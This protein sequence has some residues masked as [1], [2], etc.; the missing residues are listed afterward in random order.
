MSIVIS[1]LTPS[2]LDAVDELM[3]RNSRTLGFLPKQA[4]RDYL[5]KA[6][7]FGART[8]DGE[9]IGYLLYGDYPDYYRIAQLCVSEESRKKGIAKRLVD[10]LKET[11]TSQKFI[12][13]N[14]RRDFAAHEVWPQLGFVPLHEKPGRSAAG[15]L[16]TRWHLS[17]SADDQ[18]GLFRA[19]TS[20]ESL[21][22]VIDAQIFFD[23][24]EADNDKTAPSKALFNDF[25]T[26]ALSLWITD[27]LFVE[28]DRAQNP[29]QRKKSREK[30]HTSS[31]ISKIEHDPRAADHWEKILSTILPADS[32]S[33][34]SDIRHLAKTAA[35]DVDIF[36]TRDQ[37]LLHKSEKIAALTQMKISSPVELILK[38][39]HLSGEES[40]TSKRIS[41]GNL[42]WKRI[43]SDDLA[44]LSLD[45]F[46]NHQETK[47]KFREKLESILARPNRNECELLKVSEDVLAVRALT[48][49]S[50][51]R[52]PVP[53][54]RL[55]RQ[56]DRFLFGRFLIADMIYKALEKNLNM[57][58]CDASSLTSS[59]VPHLLDVG[60]TKSHGSFV[61][62]CFPYHLTREEVL[63][64]ITE[65]CPESIDDYRTMSD[66]D[67]ERHCSPLSLAVDQNCF[68][69][70][71]KP[72][73]ALSLIDSS[74]SAEDLFGG[75]T[76]VL[77]RWDNVYYRRK[78]HHHILNLP[79]RVLWYESSP[80][81]RIVALSH[82][83]AVEIDVPKVLFKRFKKFGILEWK[84]VFQLCQGDHSR[85]IMALK[86]SHTFPFRQPISLDTVRDVYENEGSNL[87]L[88][89]PSR[90]P[91]EVF[92]KL[93]LL[94]YPEQV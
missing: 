66:R 71:I 43:A 27:E 20:A 34:K 13:L 14:C 56:A 16:L 91:M 88:Q 8:S 75:K 28:I 47:G 26:D 9:L 54:A 22:V 89:S 49:G 69:V 38:L 55:A 79:A 86:F 94:G 53:L 72:G 85:Q 45:S 42:K 12:R 60:F 51:K 21:D 33:R 2:D 59:L 52:L 31:T 17:L 29:N 39:H 74:Q 24:Y 46:L 67:L 80:K 78:T 58:K 7:V 77:L 1:K 15:H 48:H 18:L 35:S 50:D 32:R 41:G 30:A 84:D 64:R 4:L 65:L 76:S 40:Y 11:V 37:A 3:R 36:V 44:S 5:E 61:R 6:G 10:A 63:S 82:L 93:L 62:F 23:F 81:K 90:V 92:R 73:Y 70:P 25:S 19:K 83:D 57:V 68:L 87:T